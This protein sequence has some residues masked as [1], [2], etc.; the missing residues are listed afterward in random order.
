M[1]ND[2]EHLKQETVSGAQL[3]HATPTSTPTSLLHTDNQKTAR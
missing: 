2:M 3:N 1:T